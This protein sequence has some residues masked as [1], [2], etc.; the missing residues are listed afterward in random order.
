MNREIKF[1]GRRVDNGEWVYGWVYRLDHADH[2]ERAFIIPFHA[3]ALYSYEV[4]PKT[5][6]QLTGLKDRNGKDIYEGDIVKDE[7]GIGEVEWVQEHCSHL[8]FSRNPSIYH[9]IESDGV[10]KF[11]EVIGNIYEHPHLLGEKASE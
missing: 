6:G 4:D 8:I 2:S 9:H 11:T 7:H 10:L 3:S 5:V 1:R